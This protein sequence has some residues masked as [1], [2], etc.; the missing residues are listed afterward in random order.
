MNVDITALDR[1]WRRAPSTIA[2]DAHD[3]TYLATVARTD[4]LV[5]LAEVDSLRRLNDTLRGRTPN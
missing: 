3:I 5:L 2:K 4:V 1:K